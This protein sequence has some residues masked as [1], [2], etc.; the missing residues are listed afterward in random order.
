MIEIFPQTETLPTVKEESYNCAKEVRFFCSNKL[1]NLNLQEI[2]QELFNSLFNNEQTNNSIGKPLIESNNYSSP[3]LFETQNEMIINNASGSV[4]D[5]I[6]STPVSSYVPVSKMEINNSVDNSNS[7]NFVNSTPSAIS[8]NGPVSQAEIQPTS[9]YGMDFETNAS[10]MQLDNELNSASASTAT[11]TFMPRFEQPKSDSTP[12]QLNAFQS[13]LVYYDSNFVGKNSKPAT[14]TATN[15]NYQPYFV[16]S[17]FAQKKPAFGPHIGAKSSFSKRAR[18]RSSSVSPAVKNATIKS[19]LNKPSLV[20]AIE[21]PNNNFA[22][23]TGQT[24]TSVERSNSLPIYNQKKREPN[25]RL[26]EPSQYEIVNKNRTLSG[27]YFP[28]T[29]TSP[30]SESSYSNSESSQCLPHINQNNSSPQMRK[31]S[32]TSFEK[33]S[34]PAAAISNEFFMVN[35]ELNKSRMSSRFV[36]SSNQSH[37]VYPVPHPSSS[38]SSPINSLEQSNLIAISQIDPNLHQQS[39]SGFNSLLRNDKHLYSEFEQNSSDTKTYSEIDSLTLFKNKS[40]DQSTNLFS[41]RDLQS[42]QGLLNKALSRD[43]YNKHSASAFNTNIAS[44]VY[45]SLSSSSFKSDDR[46]G[47]KERRRV[48]HIN[49]EQKR[50][51]N[52]KNGFDTL[53]N[54]LPSLNTNLNTK[55]SKAAMLHKA[56]DHIRLLKNEKYEQQKEY[57]MLKQQVKCLNQQIR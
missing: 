21:P 24:R 9:M 10:I 55:I 42:T 19:L 20:S 11:N 7:Y 41:P 36:D 16:S 26:R 40:S 22:Q 54:L 15:A 45:S 13:N 8:F 4:V 37:P 48:C 47:Y 46:S 43:S 32:Q 5:S 44:P 35:N 28:A 2:A 38:S 51:C 57:D 31:I 30:S 34:D 1:T 12:P 6:Q 33:M 27:N 17:S 3:N 49:A 53:R 18:T 52:I 25:T 39:S 23:S 14:K 56:A 29:S 50:R